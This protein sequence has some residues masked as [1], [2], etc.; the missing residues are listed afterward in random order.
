M[1]RSKSRPHSEDLY[2]YAQGFPAFPHLR[3]SVRGQELTEGAHPDGSDLLQRLT[4]RIRMF[5]PDR[6]QHANHLAEHMYGRS[7]GRR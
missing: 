7:P 2:S 4:N 3:R 5:F 1:Q 6:L